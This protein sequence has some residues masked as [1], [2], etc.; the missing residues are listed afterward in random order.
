MWICPA[1][2]S[3]RS[4]GGPVG[5]VTCSVGSDIA[6]NTGRGSADHLPALR[7]RPG[8][9]DLARR[10]SSASS[11]VRALRRARPAPAVCHMNE[12]HSAFLALERNV[13]RAFNY[14]KRGVSSRRRA[15]LGQRGER[16]HHPHTRS[17]QET[18]GCPPEHGS[19]EYFS[20]WYAALGISLGGVPG[21][22]TGG[23]TG[24]RTGGV[25]SA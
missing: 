21:A 17:R 12:G 23:R 6:G 13:D 20:D 2:T 15:K 24:R 8:D 9:A 19:S 1:A 7:R 18:I 14:R 3:R 25:H 16:L 10:S 5:R 4:L 11:G 22:G